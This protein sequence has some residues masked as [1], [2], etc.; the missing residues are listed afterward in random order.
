[1]Y[2]S[3]YS[4]SY[5][6]T[7]TEIV[8]Q[9][10]GDVATRGRHGLFLMMI[11]RLSGM[12]IALLSN[13]I[14]GRLL[15]PADYG[16]VAMATTLVVLLNLLKDFGLTTA[17]IQAETITPE[18]LDAVFWLNLIT[19]GGFA[20]AGVGAAPWIADL[21]GYAAI[22]NILYAMC[23]TLLIVSISATHGAMLRRHLQFSPLMWSEVVGQLAGLV[24]GVSIAWLYKSYW[25]IVVSQIGAAFAS[26]ALIFA[27]QRWIPGP[28]RAFSSASRLFRFG[29]NISIFSLLNFLSNQLGAIVTGA[30]LGAGPAGHFNRAQ[31]LLTLTGNGLMQ[32]ISQTSLPILSRLQNSSLA[33]RDYYLTLLRRTSLF[34]GALG[35]FVMIAGDAIALTLLGPQWSL[36]G[37]MYRWFGLSII[38]VGMASQTGNVLISQNR[39]TELRRWGFG[40]AIIRAGASGLGIMLG[41][42]GVAAAFGIA[43]LFI[44]VPIVGWIVSLKGPIKL[45]DQFHAMRPG[46]LVAL[47]SLMVG[48]GVRAIYWPTQPL[49]AAFFGLTLV[50]F[51][52]IVVFALDC[53]TKVVI[54]NA[55]NDIKKN[56]TKK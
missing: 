44:T 23:S 4:K 8:S 32:P 26:T 18:Q 7:T 13:A 41:A 28:P 47:I 35:A 19:A 55:L 37:D 39:T 42:V 31:Q 53:Q 16:L 36:A 45:T 24:I 48:L 15:K 6:K 46:S 38:A 12:L 30:W 14:M 2:L 33:Y 3:T 25:A 51:S 43:T 1:M 21:F 54:N 11:S 10:A 5:F 34:F 9:N 52:I 22:T 56:L 20:L 49:V 50:I 27:Y 17:V 40:D 29:A